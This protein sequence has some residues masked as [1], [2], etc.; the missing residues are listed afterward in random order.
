[1]SSQQLECDWLAPYRLVGTVHSNS[2]YIYTL[3]FC[4]THDLVWEIISVSEKRIQNCIVKIIDNVFEKMTKVGY[5][6]K[7]I[8]WFE[9]RKVE[10][11]LQTVVITLLMVWTA[12]NMRKRF[13]SVSVLLSFWWECSFNYSYLCNMVFN[14]YLLYKYLIL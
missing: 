9:K 6:L 11:K 8:G 7:E 1:M 4:E 5:F 2:F 3:L 14:V 12:V 13:C 10:I